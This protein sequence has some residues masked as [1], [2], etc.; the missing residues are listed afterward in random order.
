MLQNERFIKSSLPLQKLAHR[1]AH[2][3][4]PASFTMSFVTLAPSKIFPLFGNLRIKQ[5]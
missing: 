5:V 2:A 1:K 4:V 3:S